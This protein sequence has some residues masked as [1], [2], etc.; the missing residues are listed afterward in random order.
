MA[1]FYKRKHHIVNFSLQWQ[2]EIP[3]LTHNMTCRQQ[4]AA[5]GPSYLLLP[6]DTRDDRHTDFDNGSENS[7]LHSGGFEIFGD[8][9]E[10]STYGRLQHASTTLGQTRKASA[11]KDS[12]WSGHCHSAVTVI[13]SADALQSN[14]PNRAD[15]A[16]RRE[17]SPLSDCQ[18]E[19]PL[20]F[21]EKQS[22]FGIVTQSLLTCL[23]VKE[24]KPSETIAKL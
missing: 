14:L 20:N 1:V 24:T 15:T 17:G 18:I 12:S 6:N 4:H 22:T 19:K 16:T 8:V 11:S 2:H 23:R 10:S 3:S 21:N 5:V 9:P 7:S 13:E